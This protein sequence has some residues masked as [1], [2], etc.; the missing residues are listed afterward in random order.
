MKKRTQILLFL[1]LYCV[2]GAGSIPH[3]YGQAEADW[4][5]PLFSPAALLIQDK[6]IRS[7]LIVTDEQRPALE[8]LCE[9]LNPLL[10]AMRD[11]PAGTTYPEALA[12]AAQISDKLKELD[13]ILS[14]SQ[15]QRIEQ[16]RL[17]HEGI[18]ALFYPEIQ[19]QLKLTAEQIGQINQ[20][21][22][23]SLTQQKEITQQKSTNQNEKPPA[24]QIQEIQR[25]EAKDLFQ[26]MSVTQRKQW[27]TILGKP[28]NFSRVRPLTFRV[29][30]LQNV[31]E[32]IN[33]E[34]LSMESLRGRVVMVHFW[35]FECY[36][37]V[38][39]YPTYKKWIKRYDPEEVLILGI[40]TPENESE[41][42]TEKVSKQ[43]EQHGLSFAV[44]VDNDKANWNAWHNLWWPSVY[45][46][47]KKG[48]VRYWWYGELR[49]QGATGDQWITKRIE[50]LRAEKI[51]SQKPSP[52]S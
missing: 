42:N 9:T 18:G 19:S 36:N 33:T 37:C 23:Q 14:E 49:W 31:T 11:V 5:H 24:I 12:V 38:N 27:R 29:P 45:L 8:Q 47:D 25:Q 22:A 10:F 52:S 17:Q 7:E 13:S 50:E 48:R 6:T 41:K 28:F 35:T 3:L 2:F 1:L 44:A 26:T 34:P 40:H 39:N 21:H 20:I 32:W 15:Q 46:V 51:H 30:E 43:M 4:K 16:L